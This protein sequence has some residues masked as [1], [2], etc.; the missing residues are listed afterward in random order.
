MGFKV[1][2]ADLDTSFK[3]IIRDQCVVR[4]QPTEYEPTPPVHYC[5]KID[6]KEETVTVPLGL[7]SQF[8]ETAPNDDVE[9]PPRTLQ[10]RGTLYTKRTDPR[11]F[12]DQTQVLEE[13]H[14]ALARRRV[15]FLNLATGFGKTITAIA[16]AAD[17]GLKT[18]VLCHF[19]VVVGQWCDRFSFRVQRSA[20]L[21]TK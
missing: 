4:M 20:I 11:G 3:T 7:W 16:L 18:L 17:L 5:F 12:R 13:A 15:A 9:Y 10:F 21:T 2:F 6:Q 19:R 8:Y 1:P 14:A